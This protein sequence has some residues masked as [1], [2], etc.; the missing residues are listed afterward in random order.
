MLDHKGTID[1]ILFPGD[2][3]TFFH[4]KSLHQLASAR[5]SHKPTHFYGDDWPSRVSGVRNTLRAA[6][7]GVLV[8]GSLR[9]SREEVFLL[10]FQTPLPAAVRP[11]LA[12]GQ[13]VEKARLALVVCYT[14]YLCL[15]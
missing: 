1:D 5:L 11:Y 13:S 15:Y 4:L 3:F 12:L 8:P 2:N 9:F 10:R 14:V 6:P 7:Y